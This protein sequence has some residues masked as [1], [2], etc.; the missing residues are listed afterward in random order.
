[1]SDL[2]IGR[3]R[4]KKIL[5][6]VISSGRPEFVTVHGRRRV[7]KTFLIK[8]FIKDNN[9]VIFFRVTG[10]KDGSFKKQVRHITDEIGNTFYKGARLEVKKNWMETF[11]LLTDAMRKVAE[12]NKPIVLFFDEFPW[13]ATKKSLLLQAIDH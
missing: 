3:G 7:G 8:N 9:D 1:M 10:M 13:M 11:S 12:K 2:I 4:E 5:K 6:D